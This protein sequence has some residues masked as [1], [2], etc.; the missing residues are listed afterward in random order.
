MQVVACSTPI[1]MDKACSRFDKEDA[2]SIG[3]V[4]V[5]GQNPGWRTKLKQYGLMQ[6]KLIAVAPLTVVSE[7]IK[8]TTMENTG[9]T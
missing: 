6:E 1:P 2:F 9:S 5:R 7:F 4:A 8:V 3:D